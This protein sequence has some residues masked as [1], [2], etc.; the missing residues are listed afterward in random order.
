MPPDAVPISAENELVMTWNS[1]IQSCTNVD[2]C[3]IANTTNGDGDT[4]KGVNS[5]K[6]IIN[7]PVISK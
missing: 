3:T 1:W 4:R 2:D 6:K 7:K 5:R